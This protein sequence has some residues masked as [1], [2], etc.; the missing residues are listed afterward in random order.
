MDDTNASM[1]LSLGFV[2][3]VASLLCCVIICVP[4]VHHYRHTRRNEDEDAE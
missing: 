2:L 4:A 3:S 1:M